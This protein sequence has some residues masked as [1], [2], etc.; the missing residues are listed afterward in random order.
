MKLKNRVSIVTG[1]TRGIGKAIS[2]RLATEGAAVTIV[3]TNEETANRVVNHFSEIGLKVNSIIS[4]ISRQDQVN[5]M[6]KV[7]I[8]EYG[9]IDILVNNAGI[10]KDNLIVRMKEEEWDRV[11]DINLKGT[12]N[13]IKTVGRHMVKARYGRIV[14]ISSVVGISGNV[15]QA[16]YSAS[17]AGVIGLTKS[18]AREFASRNINVNAVAPGYISTDMTENLDEEAKESFLDNI[19]LRRPGSPDD[20]ARLVCFLAS[21]DSSY[22]TGQVINVDGGM[23]M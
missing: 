1:G 7:V 3:S 9:K 14:N 21:D 15:G 22:I 16:N 18:V 12:F 5:E 8:S 23:A 19:P 17:K 10:A 13:C 6:V 11:I 2:Q 4:D 20:V